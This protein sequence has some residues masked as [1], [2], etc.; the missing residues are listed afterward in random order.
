LEAAIQWIGKV[1]SKE[2]RG[3]DRQE[4]ERKVRGREVEEGVWFF[5][6]RKRAAKKILTWKQV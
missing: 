5:R 3:V 2:L 1:G 6:D 4:F